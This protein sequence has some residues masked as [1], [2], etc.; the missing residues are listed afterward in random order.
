MESLGDFHEP[1]IERLAPG[2]PGRG[3][4]RVLELGKCR[5]EGTCG[6]ADVEPVA[7]GWSFVSDDV[8][9]A[10]GASSVRER[11]MAVEPT[12]TRFD[13]VE[14]KPTLITRASIRLGVPTLE[15][16]VAADRL[17]RSV[18]PLV[19]VRV[20][21][22]SEQDGQLVVRPAPVRVYEVVSSSHAS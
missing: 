20:V 19:S 5:S 4:D 15:V 18:E 8:E 10:D 2:A 9:H 17:Q 12:I 16:G 11:N 7:G 1:P 6:Q 21:A 22:P 3:E 14:A 13:L